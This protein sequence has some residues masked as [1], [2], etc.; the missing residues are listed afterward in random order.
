MNTLAGITHGPVNKELFESLYDVSIETVRKNLIRNG[1]N[2]TKNRTKVNTG[3]TVDKD[4]DELREKWDQIR[5]GLFFLENRCTTVAEFNQRG[6]TPRFDP[7]YGQWD[8]N[9]EVG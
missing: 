9:E 8:Y 5:F 3:G 7:Y 6:P 1:W 2:G 4:Y